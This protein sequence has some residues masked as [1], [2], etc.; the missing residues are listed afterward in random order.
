MPPA[1]RNERASVSVKVMILECDGLIQRRFHSI[2]SKKCQHPISAPFLTF[3]FHLQSF[4]ACLSLVGSY[5]ASMCNAPRLHCALV[6]PR[7]YIPL[8][9]VPAPVKMSRRNRTLVARNLSGEDCCQI[10][11]IW[12]VYDCD[13]SLRGTKY[14]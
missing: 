1:V 13:Q 2:R 8:E 12:C 4:F 9:H 5:C 14:R 7:P 3:V 11:T 6:E 10:Y